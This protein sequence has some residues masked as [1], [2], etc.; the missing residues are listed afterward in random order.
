MHAPARVLVS[1]WGKA[2]GGIR[3]LVVWPPKGRVKG[4][5]GWRRGRRPVL[6]LSDL[7][8]VEL[9][10]G[11]SCWVEVRRLMSTP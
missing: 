11:V 8:Q 6:G 2:T 3:F 5:G 10:S 4:R 7:D 1:I 9:W